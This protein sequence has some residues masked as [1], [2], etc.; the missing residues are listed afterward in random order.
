MQKNPGTSLK[1]W[2]MGTNL[3]V[4]SERYSMSTNMTEFRWISKI[5][6]L[7]CMG[8]KVAFALKGLSYGTHASN[9]ND[10]L[11]DSLRRNGFKQHK[12]YL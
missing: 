1:P 6:A 11:V 9:C 4:L 5:V 8:W 10:T 12:S 2:H 3:R 7:M